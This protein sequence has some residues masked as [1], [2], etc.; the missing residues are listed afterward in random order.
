MAQG[1]AATWRSDGRSGGAWNDTQERK[2]KSSPSGAGNLA[3]CAGPSAPAS[4]T[5]VLVV[6]KSMPRLKALLTTVPIHEDAPLRGSS[7]EGGEG[8]SAQND[9]RG[10]GG[11]P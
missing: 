8:A 1:P 4:A 7:A 10:Y 9:R 11:N 2:A 6:P 5:T 3:R